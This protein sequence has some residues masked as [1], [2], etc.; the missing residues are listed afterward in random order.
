MQNQLFV[1]FILIDID[2]IILFRGLHTNTPP[3]KIFLRHTNSALLIWCGIWLLSEAIQWI[4]Q[5]P[6]INN[7]LLLLLHFCRVLSNTYLAPMLKGAKVAV[8]ATTALMSLICFIPTNC[9]YLKIFSKYNV[10]AILLLV[11]IASFCCERWCIPIRWS[12]WDIEDNPSLFLQKTEI[13]SIYRTPV[14]VDWVLTQDELY[15]TTAQEIPV[16]KE[17]IYNSIETS[18]INRGTTYKLGELAF[19]CATVS[20]G[21]RYIKNIGYIR[22]RDLCDAFLKRKNIV[23]KLLIRNILFQSDIQAA[24]NGWYLTNDYYR[25]YIPFST[26]FCFVFVVLFWAL[27]RFNRHLSFR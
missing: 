18:Q 24:E 5:Q 16:Y 3:I 23:Y 8:P 7:T 9:D 15:V 2:T 22:S 27:C 12:T 19:S 14:F 26:V 21:W 6:D 4:S 25:S 1:S 20:P 11:F 17:P 10:F 13:T